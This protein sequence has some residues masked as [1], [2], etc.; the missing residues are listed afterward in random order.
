MGRPCHREAAGEVV[1]PSP[2]FL[3]AAAAAAAAAE[4]PRQGVEA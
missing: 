4:G 2:P 3:Q 1:D